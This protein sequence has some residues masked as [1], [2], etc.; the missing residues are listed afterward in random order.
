MHVLAGG[1]YQLRQFQACDRVISAT[2][3]EL[4]VTAEAIFG[5]AGF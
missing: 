2:F 4:S 5:A 3:L 1:E